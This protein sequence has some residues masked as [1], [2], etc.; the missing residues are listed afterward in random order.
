MLHILANVRVEL[1]DLTI[2]GGLAQEQGTPGTQNGAARGGGIFNA[3][4][5][6]TLDRVVVRN[7]Q[8][9]GRPLTASNAEGGGIH[10]TGALFMSE[11]TVRDNRA[12][13][14]EGLQGSFSSVSGNFV[15][16]SGGQGV[17]GGLLVTS[18]STAVVQ[19]STFSGNRAEGGRGGLGGVGEPTF[20][21]GVGGPGAQGRQRPGRRHRRP[22]WLHA[23]AD[24]RDH[25]VEPGD[26]W[27]WRRRRTGSQRWRAGQWRQRRRWRRRR[28]LR[29]RQHPDAVQLHRG[30]QQDLHPGRRRGPVAGVAGLR[31][32][33]GL[34]VIDDNT[35]TVNSTSSLFGDNAAGIGADVAGILDNAATARWSRRP[36]A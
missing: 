5:D 15:T 26:R 9:V 23:D 17:G 16:V 8:A 35:A 34:A 25:F 18:N 6:L 10:S 33:G 7:N 13:G 22:Q 32:G 19:S 4:G 30:G 20:Q 21:A 27:P 12:I 36:P 3:G 24:Q 28:H 14:A 2:S 31:V 11:C 1:R 29:G